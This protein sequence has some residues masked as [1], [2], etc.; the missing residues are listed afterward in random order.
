MKDIDTIN[1]M[2]EKHEE[3]LMA[4]TVLNVNE[5]E[6]KPSLAAN[7]QLSKKVSKV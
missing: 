6:T 3:I 1:L 2:A 4:D 7:L 5:I